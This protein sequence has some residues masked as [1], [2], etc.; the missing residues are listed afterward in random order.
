MCPRERGRQE[1]VGGE[2]GGHNAQLQRYECQ[3]DRHGRVLEAEDSAERG[4]ERKKEEKAQD[5]P[6]LGTQLLLRVRCSPEKQRSAGGEGD[7]DEPESDRWRERTKAHCLVPS[8][9]AYAMI[10]RMLP[11][12]KTSAMCETSTA[13]KKGLCGEI[14][15]GGETDTWRRGGSP[16]GG[17]LESPLRTMMLRR[18]PNVVRTTQATVFCALQDRKKGEPSQ[19][20]RA[21][22]PFGDG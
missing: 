14:N 19:L 6:G 10:E 4:D 1:H 11:N 20:M 18:S 7:G 13:S 3:H 8:A 21:P 17:G 12:E 5:E 16:H 22:S 9:T 2:E 15:G